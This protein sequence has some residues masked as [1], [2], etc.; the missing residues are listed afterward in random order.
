MHYTYRNVNEAFTG[1]VKGIVEGTIEV[2]SSKSRNGDVLRIPGPVTVSYRHPK[3]RVLFN[4]VRDCNPFFHLYESL[5]MLGGRKDVESL[6]YYNK[7]MREFSDDGET[8]HGAYGYRWRHALG[9]DQLDTIY[10][11]LYHLPNDRRAVLQMWDGNPSG[12]SNDLVKG[13]SGGKDVPCNLMGVFEVF[14]QKLHL[15]VFNR[16][17]DLLWGMLGA[18]VVHFSFLLEY[19]ATRLSLPVGQLHQCSSNVHIYKAHWKGKDYLQSG[20][21]GLSGLD[22]YIGKPTPLVVDVRR[23]EQELQEFLDNNEANVKEPFLKEVAA[24]MCLA[25]RHHKEREYIKAYE[26]AERVQSP[27]WKSAAITWLR[28]REFLWIEKCEKQERLRQKVSKG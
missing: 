24:P 25:F 22:K 15:T 18:N 7:R 11:T 10:N 6:A 4:R 5:W 16:S 1:I 28:K 17:N 21:E 26:S 12:P 9:Y 13:G 3:E 23:F 2:S 27:D 19:M 20:T 14:K 8:F